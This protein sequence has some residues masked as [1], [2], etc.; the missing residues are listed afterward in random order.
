MDVTTTAAEGAT[1]WRRNLLVLW[2]AQAVSTPGFTFTFPF[3]PL[4]FQQ[5]GVAEP[6]RAAF[7]TGVSG[8][9]LGFG[10]FL[11][12]PIWGVVGDQ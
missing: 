5:L 2:I 9:A 4:F 1:P 3:F 7:W 10:S 6:E 12:S 11:A 8:W